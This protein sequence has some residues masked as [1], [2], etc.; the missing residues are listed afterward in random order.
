MSVSQVRLV[1]VSFGVIA[2][3]LVACGRPTVSSS[4]GDEK[5]GQ[6]PVM[7]S[8]V[9]DE[10]PATDAPVDAPTNPVAEGPNEEGAAQDEEPQVDTAP[11]SDEESGDDLDAPSG[12]EPPTEPEEAPEEEDVEP[13]VDS[14][15]GRPVGQC[16]TNGDC[17]DGPNGQRCNRGMPGGSCM[18]CG[19]DEHC[20]ESTVCYVGACVY[21]CSELNDCP[22]GLYCLG[23]G[24]CGASWCVEGECPDAMFGCSSSKRCRRVACEFRWDCPDDTT[25]LDGVCVENRAR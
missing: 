23:S 2:M 24:R 17:P 12:E 4:V 14:Y 11:P 5:G 13:E 15:P 21:E 1:L 6:A 3:A 19:S 10:E 18:G 9:P 7:E 8:T 16:T 22:P 25:C 20:P